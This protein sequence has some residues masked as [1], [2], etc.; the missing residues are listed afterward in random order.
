MGPHSELHTQKNYMTHIIKYFLYWPSLKL[1]SIEELCS[2][3]MKLKFI[4][5]EVKSNK[6]FPHHWAHY[7]IN[8]K[9]VDQISEITR[10][11]YLIFICVV[12]CKSYKLECCRVP[13]PKTS[14]MKG[15]CFCQQIYK[16]NAWISAF[17]Q[18]GFK[19][20]IIII[21]LFFVV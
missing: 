6:T 10:E 15:W 21:F 14:L 20:D 1:C 19:I 8:I 11:D 13:R 5:R 3:N 16:I 9:P 18:R 12:H 4:P 7:K 2:N 17:L